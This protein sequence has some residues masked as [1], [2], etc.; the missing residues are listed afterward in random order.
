LDQR[1]SRARCAARLSI[2]PARIHLYTVSCVEVLSVRVPREVLR[3]LDELAK[4]EGRERGEVVREILAQ[5][6]RERRVEL[7]LRLYREGRVTL[8]R[9]AELAGLS[10]WEMVGELE[11]RGVEVQYGL[12]ELEED[13][14]AALGE[15]GS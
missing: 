9:A 5:G 1:W 4:L 8:W 14:R 15:G 2:Y 12:R 10:L 7:A 3:W 6:V 13:L 11:K